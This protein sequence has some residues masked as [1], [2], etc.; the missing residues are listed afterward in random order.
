MCEQRRPNLAYYRIKSSFS[1]RQQVAEISTEI[2][3]YIL[4][5][6]L[7]A[8]TGSISVVQPD[9]KL[10]SLNYIYHHT[11]FLVLSCPQTAP[12]RLAP[13]HLGQGRAHMDNNITIRVIPPFGKYA[14][15]DNRLYFPSGMA[16][17]N[18]H[19]FFNRR[20]CCNQTDRQTKLFNRFNRS[21]RDSYIRDRTKQRLG[22][23]L[24]F[25]ALH[26]RS[27]RLG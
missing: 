3:F 1:V 26:N 16:G 13:Q 17:Q 6:N 8:T 22:Q 9:Q 18:L 10:T 2:C 19:T 5:K 15:R 21:F 7:C 11:S 27:C 4:G 24:P 12:Y 14:N 23:V 25:R 20:I